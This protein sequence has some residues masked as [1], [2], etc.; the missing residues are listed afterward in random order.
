MKFIKFYVYDDEQRIKDAEFDSF[1][2]AYD[3]A[4]DGLMTYIEAECY[5]DG[6]ACGSQII[7]TWDDVGTREEAIA[8]AAADCN[9]L[10]AGYDDEYC[11][12]EESEQYNAEDVLGGEPVEWYDFV[13]EHPV[14]EAVSINVN[15]DSPDELAG[16]TKFFFGSDF[17]QEFEEPVPAAEVEV[18]AV[19][20]E[21]PAIAVE[22]PAEEPECKGE[23]CEEQKDVDLAE[24]RMEQF[25]YPE[26]APTEQGT[27]DNLAVRLV[28][29]LKRAAV[30]FRT[31]HRN[32]EGGNWFVVH[33]LLADYYEAIDRFEDLI[34]ENLMSMGI[35]DSKL[36]CTGLLEV[37]PYS[38]E[39][40]LNIVKDRLAEIKALSVNLRHYLELP[41]S[42]APAFDELEQ[43]LEIECDYKLDKALKDAADNSIEVDKE[44]EAVGLV[45]D[46]HPTKAQAEVDRKEAFN[47]ALKIAKENNKDVI[48][49]Y[50]GSNKHGG[51]R[52]YEIEPIIAENDAD[53]DRKVSEVVK[54]YHPAGSIL[55]AY[56]DKAFVESVRPVNPEE[57]EYECYFDDE[58]LGDVTATNPSDAYYEMEQ[59]WPEYPYGLYDGVAEVI[60]KEADM[61]DEEFLEEFGKA[62][63][64]KKQNKFKLDEGVSEE[65]DF[66]RLPGSLYYEG[67]E[68]PVEVEVD[69]APIPDGKPGWAP[70]TYSPD[71]TA[72][73]V[74]DAWEY[75]LDDY[76][77]CLE[78]VAAYLKKP[79]EEV[80]QADI[81]Q[82]DLE[83]FEDFATEYFSDKAY[84]QA[85]EYAADVDDPDDRKVRWDEPEDYYDY[86]D[87]DD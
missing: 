34:I 19:T 76:A 81:D 67:F 71:Y 58:Y 30:D 69:G 2:E 40:A 75:Y 57:K 84:E 55:V 21:E 35:A 1:E 8:D 41:T 9:A 36:D 54:K 79:E 31:L 32:L 5:I 26:V 56:K 24:E 66:D 7:W 49:G 23:D 22:V 70:I 51:Y 52:Y 3:Y 29:A 87:Y 64:E 68:I 39:E 17:D 77:D 83:V 62:L 28:K 4:Q 63:A 14:D 6:K 59:M 18:P 60:E 43:W 80:V 45:E 42:V 44:V 61:S 11:P 82:L 47:K 48:Y 72:R 12:P 25:V 20:V 50:M 46:A 15:A 13:D 16:L 73:G 33:P 27:A 10:M 85:K 86:D 74:L 78:V 37:K 38:E 53:L 65:L